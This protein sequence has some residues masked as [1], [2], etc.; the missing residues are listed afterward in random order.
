MTLLKYGI[1]VLVYLGFPESSFQSLQTRAEEIVKFQEIGY[2]H[3]AK[4]SVELEKLSDLKVK[5]SED[6][7]R[8]YIKQYL[9]RFS[10]YLLAFFCFSF[11]FSFL[12]PDLGG[13]IN[14]NPDPQP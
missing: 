10:L 11:N 5:E 14:S 6:L 1:K 12:D 9:Q 7:V 4:Y 8:L 2:G 3:Y 13:K